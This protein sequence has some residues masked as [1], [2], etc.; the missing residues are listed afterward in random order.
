MSD[1]EFKSI[2]QKKEE[3]LN[4]WLLLT[5]RNKESINATEFLNHPSVE[6]LS[7][8]DQNLRQE[9]GKKILKKNKDGLVLKLDMWLDAIYEFSI[10]QKSPRGVWIS[11]GS[12]AFHL[13]RDCEWFQKG[14]NR[15]AD[16]HQRAVYKE[17]FLSEKNATLLGKRR[18]KSCCNNI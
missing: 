2:D 13:D 15:K 7:I 12:T 1:V 14:L 17:E 16:L 18:C 3:V 5:G 10:K 8:Q 6:N 9:I 4:D 11:K